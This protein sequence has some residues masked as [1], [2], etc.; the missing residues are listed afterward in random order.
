M[1]VPVMDAVASA[2]H[3]SVCDVLVAMRVDDDERRMVGM[4]QLPTPLVLFLGAVCGEEDLGPSSG[5]DSW[6]SVAFSTEKY[7]NTKVKT[8]TLTD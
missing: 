3:A 5:W 2:H 8:E 6:I 1:L 4:L 7:N